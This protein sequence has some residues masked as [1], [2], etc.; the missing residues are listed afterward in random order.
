MEAPLADILAAQAAGEF[1]REGVGRPQVE[2]HVGHVLHLAA[3]LQRIGRIFE[4][5][6]LHESHAGIGGPARSERSGQTQFE[7][8][9]PL[10]GGA[11]G[12]IAQVVGVGRVAALD[13]EQGGGGQQAL[14]EQ[15]PF[16]AQFPRCWPRPACRR[17]PWRCPR[18]R[19]ARPPPR[20]RAARRGCRTGTRCR[21]RPAWATTPRRTEFFRCR[22]SGCR[23]GPG[24]WRRTISPCSGRGAGRRRNLPLRCQRHLGEA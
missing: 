19:C 10:L 12:G 3:F 9:H 7:A 4:D 13:L 14:V 11:L 6:A 16:G 8:A 21:C 5:F 24:R 22:R 20:R 23:A 17:T 2:G 1:R 18:R 15:V